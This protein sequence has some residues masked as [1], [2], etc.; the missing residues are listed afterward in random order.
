MSLKELHR[1]KKILI[2]ILTNRKLNELFF[3]GNIIKIK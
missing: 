1:T 2:I 3:C